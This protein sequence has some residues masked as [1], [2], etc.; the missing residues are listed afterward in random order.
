MTDQTPTR[1][2][3]GLALLASLSS[4]SRDCCAPAEAIAALARHAN[5]EW[6][7]AP[8]SRP[9][10]PGAPAEVSRLSISIDAGSITP[11]G[12]LSCEVF[13]Q[14]RI[15][16]GDASR[17]ITLRDAGA[18]EAELFPTELQ[19]DGS[20]GIG[21]ARPLGTEYSCRLTSQGAD[22]AEVSWCLK[23]EPPV[24]SPRGAN[25]KPRRECLKL[26]FTEPKA[27]AHGHACVPVEPCLVYVRRR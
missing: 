4:C 7:L 27:G 14:G 16:F 21:P 23:W 22:G 6:V 1:L 12:W 13:A 17:E 19:P 20:L 5:G 8:E 2:L 26:S 15:S 18:L 9:T 24:D 11:G 10:I 25:F 3:V